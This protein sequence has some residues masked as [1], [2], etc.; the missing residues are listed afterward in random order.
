MPE[1]LVHSLECINR[2]VNHFKRSVKCVQIGT[3]TFTPPDRTVTGSIAA[4]SYFDRCSM[5]SLHFWQM[6]DKFSE[7]TI[8]FKF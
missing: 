3:A 6:S 7:A 2:I 5:N 1:L 8:N 4:S